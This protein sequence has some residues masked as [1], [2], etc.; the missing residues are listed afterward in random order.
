MAV[1]ET[2][3]QERLH[4]EEMVTRI[5]Q[6]LE[7]LDERI[8]H[9][10][11]EIIGAKKYVWENRDQLDPAE[12]AAN[13]VD[14]W[15][16]V[17]QGETSV[18][19]QSRLQKLESSPYFGR[20]D[21]IAD[22]QERAQAYYIGVTAFGVEA[23]QENAIYD[24]RSPIAS[25]FYDYQVGPAHYTAPEG[26][27]EGKI[28]LKRQYRIR[29]SKMEY[30]IES[31]MNINDDVLQKELSR[32]SD[33]KMKD[34]VATIQKEQNEIIRNDSSH[35]LIIQGVAGSGKTSVALH[36]VAYLL[37]RHKAT[38]TSRNILI[39]S[40]NNVFSDYISNV[41]PELGEEQIAE[42]GF[43]EIAANELAG[44]CEFQTFYEQVSELA[45][46][47]DDS[48]TERI[49][50]KAKMD[51][52]RRIEDFIEHVSQSY[53][54]P[55]DIHFQDVSVDREQIWDAYQASAGLPVKLRLEKTAS[56]ISGRT[57]DTD[58]GKLTTSTANKIKAAIKKMFRTQN[59]LAI[60]KDFY[61]YVGRPELFKL[62]KPRTLEFSDVFPLVYLKIR[63]EG[64]KGYAEVKHLLV[65]E[66][67]DYT[68]IQYV[69][70]ASLFKCKKTI[71]GDGNQ[72][73]NPYSSSSIADMKQ[74][75]PEADTVELFK[76]YRSTSE[77]ITFAQRINPS[78]K[79]VAIKRHGTTPQIRRC[80][81]EEDEMFRIGELV[82]Q[83]KESECR[84][85]G[86]ICKTQ[87]Q[88][89]ML[90]EKISENDRSVSLLDFSSEKFIEGVIVT[91][92]H[93]AKGLEFDKVIVPFADSSNYKTEMD[94]SLLYIAC[95][96]AMHALALTFHAEPSS[97]YSEAERQ[98]R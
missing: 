32:T 86:I 8:R 22:D 89:E 31:S 57:R 50:Y 66:M 92:V 33:E 91:T 97:F 53:F 63:M 39:I 15:L 37:Y 40:P 45:V 13:V 14:I 78:S 96:R 9:A 24:W 49:R 19:R 25:L 68:V 51:F 42:V 67:Q 17:E 77:I 72:S 2:E 55:M 90:Y 16:S 93:A 52:V 44:I 34:I 54:C 59:L 30:M 75:F 98:I 4:L 73:V 23:D 80:E 7:E 62:R 71:L 47:T 48:L 20:V 69:V 43:N 1:I 79:I 65:D 27:I 83:L 3:A 95:T 10:K 35:E 60:Y 5:R 85:L 58:G 56:S 28:G 76:S 94:R 18:M 12:R 41:L 11:D 81:N 29:E 26:E 36:R 64:A 38:L 82:A 84:T 6:A 21:F 74:V 87:A 70:L 88:A 46:S 61:A